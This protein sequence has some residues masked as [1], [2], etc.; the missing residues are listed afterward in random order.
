MIAIG[1]ILLTG[2]SAI[3]IVLFLIIFSELIIRYLPKLERITEK[4]HME[5]F[6]H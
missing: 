4:S 1:I 2:L 6:I 3:D 5:N